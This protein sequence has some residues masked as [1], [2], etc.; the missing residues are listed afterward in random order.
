MF[1]AEMPNVR[2]DDVETLKLYERVQRIPLD[3][4]F[5]E[6]CEPGTLK[7]CGYAADRPVPLGIRIEENMGET[8]II[9]ENQPEGTMATE[10][11]VRYS[12]IRKGFLGAR[13]PARTHSQFVQN[14]AFI[15]SAYDGAKA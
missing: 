1:I 4:R 3:P 15:N 11:T 2:F 12:A 9:V 10:V 14:E 7:C 5:V 6:L 8:F 13:M